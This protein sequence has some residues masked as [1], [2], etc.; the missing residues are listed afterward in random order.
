MLL[1]VVSFIDV[2]LVVHFISFVLTAR[3]LIR[4]AKSA[5]GLEKWKTVI[6]KVGVYIMKTEM[7]HIM[8]KTRSKNTP[9]Q[10]Q[11]HRIYPTLNQNTLYTQ[12][13]VS[14]FHH[15]IF[16][17]SI[18]L[19]YICHYSSFFFL[20]NWIS[21]FKSSNGT[22]RVE[23]CHVRNDHL[24]PN[25]QS[26]KINYRISTMSKGSPITRFPQC[27]GALF[28]RFPLCQRAPQSQD[29]HKRSP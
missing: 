25:H 20:L 6:I 14:V 3:F 26:T 13:Q 17:I 7:G 4:L 11:L 22:F 19:F 27:Q 18:Y 10:N 24:R 21:I 16:L 9:T 8:E 12:M 2:L 5:T 28:T 1:I 23:K 29:F 15:F